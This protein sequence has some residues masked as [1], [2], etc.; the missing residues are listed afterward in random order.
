MASSGPNG[1]AGVGG[2]L[3]ADGLDAQRAAP[4]LGDRL[5][6]D[7]EARALQLQRAQFG[8]H[9]GGQA[10]GRRLA[11]RGQ[12]GR[13][14]DHRFRARPAP[15]RS[16]SVR[17]SAAVLDQPQLLAQRHAQRRQGV[18]RGVQLS[19]GGAQGEQPLLGLVQP[20]RLEVEGVGGGVHVGDGLAAS[21]MVRSMAS[22]AADSRSDD[23]VI[24]LGPRLPRPLARVLDGAQ[25]RPTASGSAC[26]RPAGCG[27]RPDRRW[28]F[29]PRPA[30]RV[31]RPVR[32]PRRRADPARRGRP[33]SG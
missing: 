2:D 4:A 5:Q 17:A 13:R 32:S 18:D 11:R 22:A 31:R 1:V 12:E 9:R 3:E 15:S 30:W 24:A 10:V 25:G 23:R 28:P 6:R 33:G 21:T 16:A 29:P 27:R 26:R 14:P 7:A 19:G 8:H 20:A